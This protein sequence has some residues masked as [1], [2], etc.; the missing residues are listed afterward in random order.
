VRSALGTER[1]MEDNKRSR[2]DTGDS[3]KMQQISE[4]YSEIRSNFKE[5]QR[6]TTRRNGQNLTNRKSKEVIRNTR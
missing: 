6:D 1:T 5:I 2:S 4:R 3:R